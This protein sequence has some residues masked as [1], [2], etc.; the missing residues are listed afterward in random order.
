[1]SSTLFIGRIPPDTRSRELEDVFVKYGR[2]TRCD[3]KPGG[4]AFVAFEDQRD[5]EDA[6]KACNGMR[7]LGGSIVVEW[8]RG[9]RRSQ[10]N[11]AILPHTAPP[12]YPPPGYPQ[13]AAPFY[14]PPPTQ[15]YPPPYPPAPYDPAGMMRPPPQM[16][17]RDCF[18]CGRPGHFAR[19]CDRVFG[20]GSP[21]NGRR[22]S[23]SPMGRRRSPSPAA[24]RSPGQDEGN[25][26]R[27]AES[28]RW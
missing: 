6:L 11:A 10:P 12:Y 18:R 2:I 21:G 9:S 4:F 22:R 5:A 13:T 16:R 15:Y 27:G 8:A 23:P 17:S 24:V 3:V 25:N 14:P 26:R 7:F 28:P 1:M 19:D 20:S